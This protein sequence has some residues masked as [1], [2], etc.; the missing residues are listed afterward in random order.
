MGELDRVSERFE[1]IT[2]EMVDLCRRKNKDY[3]CSVSETYKQYGMVSFLVRMQDKINRVRSLIVNK[4]QEV[5]DE[6]IRDSLIDLANYSILAV[7]EL[8]KEES[9]NER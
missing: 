7:I 8:E 9:S 1:A 6:K 5:S 3:G 2:K 4:K